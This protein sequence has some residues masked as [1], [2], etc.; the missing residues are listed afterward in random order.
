MGIGRSGIQRRRRVDAISTRKANRV[1]KD[2]ERQR[3]DARMREQLK[4]GT[5]PYG[6]A[7][8]SWLSRELDKPAGKI[9]QSDVR[10]LLN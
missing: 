8:M 2:A 5:L 10:S 7:V 4:T 3:R 6:P 9:T 1:Y